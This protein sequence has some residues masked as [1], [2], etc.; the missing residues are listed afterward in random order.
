MV[1]SI[2][3]GKPSFKDSSIY[4]SSFDID[5]NYNLSGALPSNPAALIYVFQIKRVDFDSYVD[6]DNVIQF[7]ETDFFDTYD[8]AIGGMHM[9][10]NNSTLLIN[11]NNMSVADV[12]HILYDLDSTSASGYTGRVINIGGTN[13]DPDSSSGGYDGLAAKA[14]LEGKGFTIT[15]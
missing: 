2:E 15:I 13:A 1:C 11:N 8:F 14:A 6:I 7:V 12:N 10:G 5:G 9:N 4:V 3:N